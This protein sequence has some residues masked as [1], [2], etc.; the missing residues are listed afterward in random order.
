MSSL[1]YEVVV[2]YIWWYHGLKLYVLAYYVHY[3]L[4][5]KYKTWIIKLKSLWYI[6]KYFGQVKL[7]V[8]YQNL[9]I[10]GPDNII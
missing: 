7:V 8:Q 4:P 6:F 3:L 10:L 1:K 2:E 5:Y 9:W